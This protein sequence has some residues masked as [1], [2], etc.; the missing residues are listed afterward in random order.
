MRLC[1]HTGSY[2]IDNNA[3][4][5]A[6]ITAFV[7]AIVAAIPNL[8]HIAVGTYLNY[9]TQW[10]RWATAIH[11]AGKKMWGRSAGYNEWKG[12]NGAAANATSTALSNHRTN[13]QTF[14]A[15]NASMFQ[16]GDIFS[17]VPDEPE[18][19][20]YLLTLTVDSGSDQ[21]TYNGFITGAITD[22]DAA[23]ATAGVS[24]V[25]TNIVG[26]S[27]YY[28]K[29]AITSA[30]AAL[31]DTMLIDAYPEGGA[32]EYP[33]HAVNDPTLCQH[34]TKNHI[35]RWITGAQSRPYN[36]TMGPSIYLQME[37][38]VQAETIKREVFTLQK[39][40]SSFDGITFWQ[41]GG[42]GNPLSR[43]FDYTNS[44]WVARQGATQLNNL[45]A[46]LLSSASPLKRIPV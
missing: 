28:T 46:V 33:F 29:S 6:D 43:L 9:D 1:I 19:G 27:P 25:K 12:S 37:Q 21:T 20:S 31:L 14:I 10:Q 8:T 15:N 22:C 35:D 38:G 16:S 2:S 41:A 32:S 45:F 36:Y 17:A 13:I 4:S 40:L 30:T 23:L 5:Q 11:A 34:T 24:G 44:A 39:Y 3:L 18:S 7:S 42:T 26:T